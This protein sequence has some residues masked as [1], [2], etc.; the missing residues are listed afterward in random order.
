MSLHRALAAGA[1]LLTSLAASARAQDGEGVAGGDAELPMDV[2]AGWTAA[3]GERPEL[4]APPD[5]YATDHVG[6]VTW[7][8]PRAAES[9]AEELMA[10]FTEA[11]TAITVELGAAV[12]SDMVVRIA[13]NPDEMAALAPV[14]HPPPPYATGVAYPSFGVV[15]LTLT[16]PTTWRRPPMEA[17]LRHELSHIALHRAVGGQPLPRWFVEG[18]AI[19]QAREHSFPRTRTLWEATVSGELIPLDRLSERFPTRPHD[20]N[21]AYAESAD[22]V[23][24]LAGEDR[25]PRRLRRLVRALR[26][27]TPFEGAIASAYDASLHAL[28]IEWR[29]ELAERYRSWPLLI[30]GGT[31][32]TLASLLLILAWWRRR[33]RAKKKLAEWAAEEAA[34]DRLEAAVERRLAEA[35]RREGSSRPSEGS[36]FVPGDA[37]P[38]Q[39]EPGVPTVEHEGRSYTLH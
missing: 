32:W 36:F 15:L 1:L 22:F 14:G 11:W 35:S 6:T 9:D 26:E 19:Y 37:A 30:G 39:R 25:D 16:A 8:Y 5:D 31:I 13:R 18:V 2:A 17:V 20:V 10:A 33:R 38:T 24:F 12:E 29:A 28:E 7:T 4:P 21:L 3:T 23:R 27:G 34:I